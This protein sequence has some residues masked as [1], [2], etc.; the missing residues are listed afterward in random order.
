MKLGGVLTD[1]QLTSD[2]FIGQT[3]RDEMEDLAFTRREH[4]TALTGPRMRMDSGRPSNG[5]IE[6][7]K[8]GRGGSDCCGERQGVDV[9]GQVGDRRAGETRA[10]RC[11]I[12]AD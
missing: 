11:R 5:R 12:R 7:D 2:G 8:T 6:H 9:T 1:A 10:V 4:L 3:F